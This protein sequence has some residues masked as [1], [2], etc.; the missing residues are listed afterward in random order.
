VW[1]WEV[2]ACVVWGGGAWDVGGVCGMD[3][4]VWW[5]VVMVG[6]AVSHPSLLALSQTHR[7]VSGG[8]GGGGGWGLCVLFLG[9]GL[10][11]WVA[12]VVWTQGFGGVW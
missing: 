2:V 1:G 6:D 12:F 3:I 7:C 5:S 9:G 4:G 11:M 10:G 8:D